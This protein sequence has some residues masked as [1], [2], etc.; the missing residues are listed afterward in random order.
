MIVDSTDKATAFVQSDAELQSDD[1]DSGTEKEQNLFVQ[2]GSTSGEV[3]SSDTDS[4]KESNEF[5]QLIN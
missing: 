5:L 1:A 2:D 3:S 4:E